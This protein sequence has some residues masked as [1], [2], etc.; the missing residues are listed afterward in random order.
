MCIYSYSHN[1]N[2]LFFIY[3]GESGF[4]LKLKNN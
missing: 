1:I 2:K 4:N 3:S